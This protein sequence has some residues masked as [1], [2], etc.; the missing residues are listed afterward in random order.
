MIETYW[1]GHV[2]VDRN[3][4]AVSKAFKNKVDAIDYLI[5]L[6]RRRAI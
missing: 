1:F 3:G 6:I 5:Q 4:V 2:V